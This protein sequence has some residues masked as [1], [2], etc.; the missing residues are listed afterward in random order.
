MP[1][2]RREEEM[3][4]EGRFLAG[5]GRKGNEEIRKDRSTLAGER[6]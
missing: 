6:R 3:N 2:G 1:L 4:E 5:L